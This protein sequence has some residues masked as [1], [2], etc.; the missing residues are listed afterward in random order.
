MDCEFGKLCR[1]CNTYFDYKLLVH[2]CPGKHGKLHQCIRCGLLFEC[3]A[4]DC[5]A[6]FRVSPIIVTANGLVNHCPD[7]P[8]W[9]WIREYGRVGLDQLDFTEG[10]IY[11][12]SLRTRKRDGWEC[13]K[14]PHHKGECS[15]HNDCGATNDEGVACGF[16]PDHCGRHAWE[17][18]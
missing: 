6:Q 9:D 3:K 14:P 5:K 11:R 2:V 15:C 17:K 7:R 4:T 10:V 18:P 1:S 16:P 12:C 8:S 13:H